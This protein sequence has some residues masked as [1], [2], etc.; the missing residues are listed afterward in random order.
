M[1][2]G[3]RAVLSLW[4]P[5]LLIQFLALVFVVLYYQIP[6]LQQIPEVIEGL[7]N[8]FG[9]LWTL[10]SVWVSSIVISEIAAKITMPKR[11]WTPVKTLL[12][13]TVYYAI[14]GLILEQFYF[15]VTGL[16]GTSTDPWTVIRKMMLDQLIFSPLISMPYAVTFFAWKDHQFD[17]QK[18]QAALRG[19]GFWRRYFP[20][21]A[22]CW[23]YFGPFTIALYNLPPGLQFPMSMA[24]QA[25]WSLI[26]IAVASRDETGAEATTNPQDLAV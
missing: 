23:M 24:A 11:K 13:L 6:S 19:G 7:R 8:R 10:I 5:I 17:W 14:I 4:R 1:L 9:I 26:V 21:L 3:I 2:P 16:L 15:M 18:T 20:V 22:T 25:A 12:M